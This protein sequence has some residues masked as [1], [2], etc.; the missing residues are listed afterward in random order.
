MT[1]RLLRGGHEVVVYDRAGEAVQKLSSEGA[2]PADDLGHLVG[3]LSGQDEAPRV[4]W[5]ML[6][7]GEVTETVVT[8]ARSLLEPGDILVDGANS[9]WKDSRRRAQE[10]EEKGLHFVDAGVSGGIW[11]LKEGY[12]LMVGGPDEA[13]EA[14]E[15][16][17]RTLAPEGGYAHLG[18]AGTGHFVK[19]VHNGIEYALMQSYGEGFEAMAAYPHAEL[20]LEEIAKLWT[21]GSV[22]RSWLLELTGR[23]L[24]KDVRLEN[25]QAYVDDSGMG[26]W[27]VEY[28]VEN[29]VPMAAISAALFARFSSRQT[30]SFAAKVAAALRNEFGGHAVRSVSDPKASESEKVEK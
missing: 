7:A 11:G 13:F 6:P 16:A 25:I 10:A 28:G 23:A 18:P 8:E 27:T 17:L 22:I 9:H 2:H 26:R 3:Q 1:R 21:H 14:L 20:D 29:A 19:M 12:N 30:D 5:L 15:P 4:L 24:E